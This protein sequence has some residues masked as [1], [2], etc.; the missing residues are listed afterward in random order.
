[1]TASA[2]YKYNLKGSDSVAKPVCAHAM[3]DDI[4]FSYH[5]SDR[6]LKL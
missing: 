6:Y 1:M 5:K 2:T 4:T 3:H